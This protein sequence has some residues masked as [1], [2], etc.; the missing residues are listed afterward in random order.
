MAIACVQRG[1]LVFAE[2]IVK[3]SPRPAR[4]R[5]RP[6]TLHGERRVWCRPTECGGCSISRSTIKR[7]LGR[8]KRHARC[9]GHGAQA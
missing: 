7:A 2:P 5:S 9:V 4:P 6:Q 1:D 3:D 8:G